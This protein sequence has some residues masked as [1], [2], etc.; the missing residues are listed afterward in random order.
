MANFFSFNQKVQSQAQVLAFL[1]QKG[2]VGKTTLTFN[3]AHALARRGKKVL[4]ID[5]DPQANLSL[6][7]QSEKNEVRDEEAP[8]IYHLLINSLKELK[9]LHRPVLLSDVI[10]NS[11]E[12]DQGRLDF[13]SS[14]HELSGFDLSVAAIRSPR[15]L[16][17]KK[18]LKDQGALEAYDYILI[19]SPP[20]L[21]LLVVNI[22][23][24]SRGIIVPFRPDDFSR[25]G[26]VQLRYTLEEIQDMGLSEVPRI[27]AYVPNLVDMR[28]RVETD[29]LDKIIEELQHL[30]EDAVVGPCFYNRSLVSK[31]QSQKKSVFGP[32]SKDYLALQEHFQKLADI[33]EERV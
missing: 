4:C 12:D 8:H 25:Q 7:F 29:Y 19:D 17:L 26:L 6:L 9:A 27:L 5:F 24:A 13:I 3:L 30:D 10:Q 11:W 21:G 23:C 18:F 32:N 2:G 16:I 31:L 28:R 14:G 22:L 33:I 1:N 15:Q 20:T